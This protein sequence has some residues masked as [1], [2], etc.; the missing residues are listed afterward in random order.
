MTLPEEGGDEALHPI[1]PAFPKEKPIK[2]FAR[3][4]P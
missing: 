2:V 3:N 1:I 4:A